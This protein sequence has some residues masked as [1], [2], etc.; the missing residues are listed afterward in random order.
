MKIE[1][2]ADDGQKIHDDLLARHTD[3]QCAADSV[4]PPYK[5]CVVYTAPKVAFPLKRR[6]VEAMKVVR[7]SIKDID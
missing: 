5:K 1:S 4:V 2:N 3:F 7:V 6:R